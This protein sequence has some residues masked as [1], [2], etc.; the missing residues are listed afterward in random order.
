VNPFRPSLRQRVALALGVLFVLGLALGSG[1]L[2]LAHDLIFR[3]WGSYTRPP[4]QECFWHNGLRIPP[5]CYRPFSTAT[6]AW[7]LAGLAAAGLL[8][9]WACWAL[10]GRTLRPLSRTVQ[11]VH[12]LG[13]Q[14]L[15]QR[16]E[17]TGSADVLKELA[18][19]L[20][21]ALERLAAGY[22]GQRRFAANASHELR[23]PLAVQRLLTEVAMDDPNAGQDLR[24]LGA[25]LIR[26][27]ERN[28]RL[29]EGLLVLA[30]SDRGLPG[31]VPVR[32]DQLAGSVLDTH[33]EL[34]GK[35][36]VTLHRS[37]A[38]RLI[39]GDPLLLERLI[40]NLVT[41]AITYN[42][43]GG[44]VEVEV[45]A[46]TEPG[47]ALAVRN[48][49]QH[50]PAQAVSSLFEPFRRLTADRTNHTGGAG[51]GL[52]IAR[53]ITAAHGGAIR[54]RPRSEGGLIVEIELP[55]KP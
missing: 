34:A 41:N 44:W 3:L 19:A 39:P 49:G 11:T 20:D 42:Q 48:T 10:A 24:R 8:A 47:P 2:A 30:E 6:H 37:L 52:S 51:L 32:L 9:A 43:P 17:M 4:G 55:A 21:G 40:S 54:A 1:V 31:K 23:T 16:I 38:E 27:N 5:T 50:I 25:Q 53:S 29:I 26:V 18:D 13:P 15:R 45:T 22:E 35:H 7:V 46:E 12:Q 28:E 36:E 14:N 33:Q